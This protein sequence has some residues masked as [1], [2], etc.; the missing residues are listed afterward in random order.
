VQ[1]TRIVPFEKN[2][3]KT[4]NHELNVFLRKLLSWIQNLRIGIGGGFNQ[5][6]I[7]VGT[8]TNTAADVLKV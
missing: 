4:I 7:Y 2:I 6:C 5:I 1:H 3:S 8:V